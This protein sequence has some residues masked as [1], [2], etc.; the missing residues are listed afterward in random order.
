MDGKPGD[1]PGVFK[2]SE[3][4]NYLNNFPDPNLILQIAPLS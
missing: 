3:L 2:F 1:Y 4:E